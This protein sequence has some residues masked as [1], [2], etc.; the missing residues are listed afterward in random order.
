MTPIVNT[1][2]PREPCM[3]QPWQRAHIRPQ[4]NAPRHQKSARAAIT[5][6]QN[7][8]AVSADAL[9]YRRMFCKIWLRRRRMVSIFT[10][11]ANGKAS[12]MGKAFPPA[13]V[14]NSGAALR[15]VYG[16]Y[17]MRQS[18]T[19]HSLSDLTLVRIWSFG[20]GKRRR[21]NR[22]G[23]CKRM[24]K[25]RPPERVLYDVY[26][27]LT[28]YQRRVAALSFGCG[29]TARRCRDSSIDWQVFNDWTGG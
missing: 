1:F 6:I 2:S 9:N 11:L 26:A 22:L 29:S 20:G 7:G 13:L 27:D 4:Y 16:A 24:F 23:K 21:R 19:E 8:T 17:S 3:H 28:L 15:Y 14:S 18:C 25:W 10:D 5:R 12:D